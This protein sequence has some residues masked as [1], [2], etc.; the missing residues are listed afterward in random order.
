MGVRAW[1]A[2]RSQG[3]RVAVVLAGG[4]CLLPVTLAVV[5]LVTAVVGAFVLGVDDPATTASPQVQ[6]EFESTDGGVAI[7]HAGGDTVRASTLRVVVDETERPWP[8]RGEVAAGD[9][10]TVPA[11]ADS[12]VRVVWVDGEESATLG[13][14]TV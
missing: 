1:W 12:T 6:F 3:E 10:V 8:G 9:R 13:V 2:E 11:G 4:L 14:Y 5:V 7:S